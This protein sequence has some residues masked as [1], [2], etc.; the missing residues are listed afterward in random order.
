MQKKAF[1]FVEI[2]MVMLLIGVLVVISVP[3]MNFS[4]IEKQK[5]DWQARKIVTDLNRTRG[6]AISNAATNTTGFSLRMTGSEP[7]SEYKII[8]LSTSTTITNGTFSIDSDVTCT[9]GSIFEFGPLGNLK[10]GSDTEIKV[11][12]KGKIFTINITPATGMV[13]CTEN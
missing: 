1:T 12:A 4:F 11:S 2:A 9:D 10:T 5:A 8:D 13:K 6:L 7:Y 3:R